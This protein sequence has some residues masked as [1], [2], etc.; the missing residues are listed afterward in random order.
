MAKSRR[1]TENEE[2]VEVDVVE[3]GEQLPLIDVEPENAKAI[4]RVARAYKRAQGERNVALAEEVKQKEKLLTL[5]KDA[6]IPTDSDGNQRFRVD[7]AVFTVKRRDALVR[8]KFEQD[9]EGE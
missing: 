7:G 2:E 1:R 9:D 8:V 4:M 5:I 3:D 6:N